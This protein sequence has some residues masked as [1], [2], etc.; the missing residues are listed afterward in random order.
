MAAA[1]GADVILFETWGHSN[2]S[3]NTGHTSYESMQAA[4]SQGYWHLA[5]AADGVVAPVGTTWSRS[6]ENNDIVLYEPDGYHP[7]VAGSHL[8]SLVIA[9]TMLGEALT[10]FPTNGL[11]DGE[12]DQLAALVW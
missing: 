4:L 2:G 6:L 9:R 7:S 3:T 12:A 10:G 11:P 1:A 5:D 8:A